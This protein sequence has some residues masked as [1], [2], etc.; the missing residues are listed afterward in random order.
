MPNLRFIDFIF[1]LFFVSKKCQLKDIN[2]LLVLTLARKE[3]VAEIVQFY[4]AK[5]KGKSASIFMEL[6]EGER[7]LKIV[8]KLKLSLVSVQK[9]KASLS[10][11]FISS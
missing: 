5:L 8:P 9:E 4:G 11:L 7:L 6:M 2:E 1:L 10:D 3:S